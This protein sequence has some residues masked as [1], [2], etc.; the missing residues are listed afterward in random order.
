MRYEDIKKEAESRYKLITEIYESGVT[1]VAEIAR[2]TSV[3]RRTVSR[4][5]L[6]WKALVPVEEVKA[7]VRPP[8]ITSDNR[9]FIA[10]EIAK[11]TFITAKNLQLR[12]L[13]N[14]RL[15]SIYTVQA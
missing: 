14:G 15:D 6:M 10:S 11:K 12:L 7:N 2:K 1:C 13:V 9:S 5:I 8:K 3:S 4:Y